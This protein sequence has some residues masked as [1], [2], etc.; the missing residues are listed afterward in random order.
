MCSD[1]LSMHMYEHL[2]TWDCVI[3]T[4]KSH[5]E[6]DNSD[7]QGLDNYTTELLNFTNLCVHFCCDKRKCW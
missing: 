2:L 6:I 5:L 1:E 3:K 7:N 4:I